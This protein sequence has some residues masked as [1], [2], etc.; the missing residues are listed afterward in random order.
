MRA[1]QA[2]AINVLD[3]KGCCS[4]T[5]SNPTGTERTSRL[6][7]ATIC[8]RASFFHGAS[9][10]HARAQE[11][12]THRRSRLRALTHT[13]SLHA[14][15]HQTIS[16]S[17]FLLGHTPG[18]QAGQNGNLKLDLENVPQPDLALIVLPTT[19]VKPISTTTFASPDS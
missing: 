14:V 19:V 16:T 5:M 7:T 10:S 9:S 13:M 1:W 4:M 2:W 15:P 12:G 11:S 18:T 6:K 8:P 17:L 3:L